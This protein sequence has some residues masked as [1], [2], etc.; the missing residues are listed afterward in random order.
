MALEIV[1]S[2]PA[3]GAG[4][5]ALATAEV[6]AELQKKLAELLDLG[7]TAP[8]QAEVVIGDPAWQAAPD[9]AP[10]CVVQGH[11]RY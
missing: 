4:A 10:R 9:G 7:L 1:R 3:G 6:R 2:A 11:I 8:G 5:V